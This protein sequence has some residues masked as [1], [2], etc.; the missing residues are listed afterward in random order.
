[1]PMPAEQLHAWLPD[2]AAALDA[3]HRQGFLHRDV[4]PHNILFD[5]T[6]RAYLSDFGL[7]KAMLGDKGA[8]HTSSLTGTG[9]VIGTPAYL[10]PEICKEQAHDGKVDQYA[11]AATVYEWLCGRPPFEGPSVVV[12]ACHLNQAPPAPRSLLASL[13]EAVDA[14]LLRALAKE[15]GERFGSCAEFVKSVLGTPPT[16]PSPAP[17]LQ[18]TSTLGQEQ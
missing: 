18:P 10:A 3:I 8:M 2:I 4:K 14:A 9:Q 11:L 15:P 12:L 13:S 16:A 5:S 7:V 17:L 1:L 6:G